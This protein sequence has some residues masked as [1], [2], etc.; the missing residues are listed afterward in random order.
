MEVQFGT[1]RLDGPIRLSAKDRHSA[2]NS[3]SQSNRSA[4]SFETSNHCGDPLFV[5]PEVND[6]AN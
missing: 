4:Q 6:S 5:V 1:S 3:G 2:A